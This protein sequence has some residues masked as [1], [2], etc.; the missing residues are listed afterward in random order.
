MDDFI[1]SVTDAHYE[2]MDALQFNLTET[3]NRPGVMH[4]VKEFAGAIAWE[5]PFFHWLFGFHFVLVCLVF[6]FCLHRDVY[7]CGALFG[8]LAASVFAAEQINAFGRANY[9]WLFPIHKTN[10][11]DASGTFVSAIFSAPVLAMAFV[12]QL[13]MLGSVAKM[14][15]VVKRHQAR[16]QAVRA[17]QSAI[18]A[19]GDSGKAAGGGGAGAKGKKKQKK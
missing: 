9:E 11:F 5:E 6:N 14:L 8:L 3:W 18:T 4:A 17:G 2:V 15:V 13:R 19:E 10:Y 1:K 12:L 16:E 7:A